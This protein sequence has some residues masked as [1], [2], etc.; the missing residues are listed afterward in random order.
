MDQK[1]TLMDY[2]CLDPERNQSPSEQILNK[3]KF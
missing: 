1:R 2:Y 3:T